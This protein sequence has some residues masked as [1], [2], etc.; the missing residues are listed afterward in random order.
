MRGLDDEPPRC[1]PG[2]KPSSDLRWW[3]QSFTPEQRAMLLEVLE[4]A[5]RT[6]VTA[7]TE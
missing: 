5:G 6:P 2:P 4:S 1:K 3:A 7:S